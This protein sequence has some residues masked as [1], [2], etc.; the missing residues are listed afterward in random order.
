M[1]VIASNV[2][3][4]SIKIK[5]NVTFMDLHKNSIKEWS[6]EIIKLLNDTRKREIIDSDFYDY[7]IEMQGEKLI[8]YYETKEEK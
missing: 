3:P 4:N 8:K 1:P 7:D 2:V 5:E 6:N